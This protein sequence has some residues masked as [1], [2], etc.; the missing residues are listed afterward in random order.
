MKLLRVA[1]RCVSDTF[2]HQKYNRSIIIRTLSTN[3]NP[4]SHDYDESHNANSVESVDDFESRI[5]GGLSK[6]NPSSLYR[7]LDNIEKVRYG[8]GMDS[9][10][11]GPGQFGFGDGFST[12]MDGFDVNLKNA[13]KYFEFDPEE[14]VHDDYTFRP[15]MNFRTGMTYTTEDL[16]LKKPGV[17]KP[18]KRSEFQVTSEEVLKKAD[19]RNVRFLANFLTDAGI[20]IKRSKTG[21]SAKAQRKVAREIK[22]A[23]A[24]GLLP[25]TTMGTKQF[26]FGR[27]MEALDEDYQLDVYGPAAD[28]MQE[29]VAE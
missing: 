23:R 18:S 22:I 2:H 27:T 13:A 6:D 14:V 4:V 21:I 9:N 10:V 8:Q 1:V 15:D 17:W 29:P 19:F 12:V 3:L 28:D 7:K 20:I 25:F 16:N 24:F 11:A 5:F 26:V